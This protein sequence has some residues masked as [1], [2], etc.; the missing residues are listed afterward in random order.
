MR[1]RDRNSKGSS[2]MQ[3][4][5]K[6]KRGKKGVGDWNPNWNHMSITILQ[7]QTC[8]FMS[9]RLQKF[10]SFDLKLNTEFSAVN[11]FLT[12]R[13]INYQI[14]L[15]VKELDTSLIIFCLIIHYDSSAKMKQ[16]AC[17]QGRALMMFV[18]TY[19]VHILLY[20]LI[21][22]ESWQQ[23]YLESWQVLGLSLVTQASYKMHLLAQ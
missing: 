23:H 6:K 11:H 18:R 1:E 21:I 3:A 15:T 9:P 14:T 8:Q 5:K 20:S 12:K 7:L 10:A 16:N 22:N 19:K 4:N 13:F 2:L 17:F